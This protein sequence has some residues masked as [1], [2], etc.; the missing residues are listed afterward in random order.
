MRIS[1]NRTMRL[2]TL[3]KESLSAHM[4]MEWLWAEYVNTNVNFAQIATIVNAHQVSIIY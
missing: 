3:D 2:G 1:I 4:Q